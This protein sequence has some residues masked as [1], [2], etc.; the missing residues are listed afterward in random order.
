MHSVCIFLVKRSDMYRHRK[1][2]NPELIDL[3]AM[4][5]KRLMQIMFYGET[6][7]GEYEV[8][9]QTI[10]LIQDE[11]LARRNYISHPA[12]NSNFNQSFAVNN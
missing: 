4:Q 1:L 8:C 10:E 6:F 7:F 2:E 9:K 11:I 3:L 12:I 5:T